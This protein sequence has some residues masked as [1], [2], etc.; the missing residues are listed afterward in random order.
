MHRWSYSSP[1][2]SRS[3]KLRRATEWRIYASVNNAIPLVQIM[4]CCLFGS[5]S[6]SEPMLVYVQLDPWVKFE[7]KCEDF[8]S[9]KRI[10]AD[11][12]I[13]IHR[14]PN[15]PEQQR[16]RYSHY[17]GINTRKVKLFTHAHTIFCDLFCRGYVHY[18][19][20]IMITMASQI[21]GVSIVWIT[22]FTR[23]SKE[24]IKA[25]RH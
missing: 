11:I 14:V 19:D 10:V 2:Y 5:K 9:G 8:H 22:I 6:L 15:G 13:Y 18:I 12:Y 20:V 23:G 4:A 1:I 17:Y 21:T 3:P 16:P 7:S 24:N 25:P